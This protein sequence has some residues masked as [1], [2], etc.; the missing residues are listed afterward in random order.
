MPDL[1]CPCLW[2]ATNHNQGGFSINQRLLKLEPLDPSSNYKEIW[3]R[4]MHKTPMQSQINDDSGSFAQVSSV[5]QSGSMKQR[6]AIIDVPLH[7]KTRPDQKIFF[8]QISHNRSL[9]CGSTL[10]HQIHNTK[11]DTGERSAIW[12]S[13][14]AGKDERIEQCS[15]FY[16]TPGWKNKK[17][18]STKIWYGFSSEAD[19]HEH[20]RLPYRSAKLNLQW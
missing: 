7:M 16:K 3:R 10:S 20:A 18:L 17:K 12:W 2:S 9:S 6:A 11:S 5:K 15:N 8:L 4:Q 13:L 19:H 14:R 1:A